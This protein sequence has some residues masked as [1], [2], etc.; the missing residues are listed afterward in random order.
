MHGGSV[1]NCQ[2]TMNP[3]TKKADD[4]F[5]SVARQ[6]VECHDLLKPEYPYPVCDRCS[7]QHM[8]EADDDCDVCDRCGGD[9]FIEYA[10]AGPSEWGEDCPSKMNHLIPCP[11]CRGR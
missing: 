9:G 10:D 3:E 2:Q 11:E 8:I 6:C 7:Q 4:L 1:M 5:P